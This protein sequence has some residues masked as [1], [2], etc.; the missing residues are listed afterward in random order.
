MEEEGVVV[1]GGEIMNQRTEVPI[2]AASTA[3]I[4]PRPPGGDMTTRVLAR[5]V[6]WFLVVGDDAWRWVFW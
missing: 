3:V 2:V 6:V 5:L 4:S 1:V